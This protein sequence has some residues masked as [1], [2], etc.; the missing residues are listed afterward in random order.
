[1]WVNGTEEGEHCRQSTCVSR[2]VGVGQVWAREMAG[3]AG[4]ERAPETVG[5]GSEDREGS[6]AAL[7][8]C[9]GLTASHGSSGNAQ[10]GP[11]V[12]SVGGDSVRWGRGSGHNEDPCAA[13]MLPLA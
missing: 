4:S 12:V 10:W 1:M 8:S 7:C 13:W 5:V 6:G 3:P 11:G 9:W 2:D